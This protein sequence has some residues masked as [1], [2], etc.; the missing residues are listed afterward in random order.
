MIFAL[1]ALLVVML[2]LASS[3]QAIDEGSPVE[4]DEALARYPNLPR[5]A[6]IVAYRLEQCVH[7]AGEFNGDGSEHDAEVN[8]IMVELRCDTIK[9]EALDLRSRYRDSE[10]VLQAMA[11]ADDL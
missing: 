8:R 5:D 4:G 9:Q 1:R 7:F 6:A 11:P 2:A 3:A 10:A